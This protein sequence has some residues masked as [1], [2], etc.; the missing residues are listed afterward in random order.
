MSVVLTV[1]PCKSSKLI[2]KSI[3]ERNKECGG[4][5]IASDSPTQKIVFVTNDR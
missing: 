2:Q 1:G 4:A 3:A 5:M